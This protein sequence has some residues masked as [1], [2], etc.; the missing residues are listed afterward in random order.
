[1]LTVEDVREQVKHASNVSDEVTSEASS[2]PY[3]NQLKTIRENGPGHNLNGDI[4]SKKQ[5]HTRDCRLLFEAC[6]SFTFILCQTKLLQ[7][8][9]NV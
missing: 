1:M 3:I 6:V 8:Y 9:Q 4:F 2:I 5:V 7:L